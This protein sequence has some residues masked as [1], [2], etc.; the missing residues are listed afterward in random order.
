MLFLIRL[1][2]HLNA[3]KFQTVYGSTRSGAEFKGVSEK[4]QKQTTTPHTEN[5]NAHPHADVMP[6]L[7]LNIAVEPDEAE[8]LS[9]F[10]VEDYN[11][12]REDGVNRGHMRPAFSAYDNSSILSFPNHHVKI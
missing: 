4:R 3:F 1:D 9:K 7:D 11:L 2:N 10:Y 5:N 12:Q 8:D 6:E